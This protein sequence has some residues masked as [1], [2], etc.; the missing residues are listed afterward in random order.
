MSKILGDL[1]EKGQILCKTV[2]DSVVKGAES[3]QTHLEEN[4]VDV[5]YAKD[6]AVNV[7]KLS[8]L[9]VKKSML[10]SEIE[11]QYNL[12]GHLI[13]EDGIRLENERALNVMDWLYSKTKDLDEISF[14][15]SEL[16]AE[17]EEFTS[18]VQENIEDGI[19]ELKRTVSEKFDIDDDDDEWGCSCYDCDSGCGNP[20]CC[21]ECE[22][23]CE[24]AFGYDPDKEEEC[25]CE[26][27]KEDSDTW[28]KDI[29]IEKDDWSNLLKKTGLSDFHKGLKDNDLF[30]GHHISESFNP[31]EN[32][33]LSAV[34]GENDN[35]DADV[36]TSL[37]EDLKDKKVEEKDTSTTIPIKRKTHH[38]YHN[39][40]RHNNKK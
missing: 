31:F 20:D 16:K 5:A 27:C 12:L 24:N 37:F 10:E 22:S 33:K 30:E 34:D 32:I 11:K 18:E 3:I 14:E 2:A 9:L 17:I 15:I 23:H 28:P 19:A 38:N 7:G 36:P 1:I 26:D 25:E 6:T 21:K 8:K 39:H 40:Q 13:F 4:G 29:D 35:E